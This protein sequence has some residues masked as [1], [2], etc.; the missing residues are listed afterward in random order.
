MTSYKLPES[1][2]NIFQVFHKAKFEIYAVGGAVRDLIMEKQTKDWDFT[3]NARPEEIL[4]IFP[5]GFYNN[6]FGTVGIPQEN[7]EVYE[8][9]TYRT[10]RDYSDRRHPDVVCWGESLEEDL[11]RRDFTVNAIALLRQPADQGKPLF[12]DPF[13]GQKDIQDKVIRAVGD[14]EKRFSEDILRL[15]RAVRI[16]TELGFLIEE[17]TFQAIKNNAPLI[18]KVS[19]ERI[20]EELFKILGSDFPFEGVSLLQSSGLLAQILPEI[21]KGFGIAQKSPGRHHVYDVGEHS[22]LSLKFCPSKNPLVRLATLCHDVGKPV[23]FK[24]DEKG[25]ITFYNHELIGASTARNIAER[26]HFSKKER[27]KFVTLIRWHQFTV[28]E[29]QTDASIRR[30]IKRVGAENLQDIFDL[31]IGDRLGGGCPAATSWRLR[32]FMARTVEVQKHTPST[33]DLKIDGRDVMRE[34]GI[35]PGPKVGQI[36]DILFQEI[37]EDNKKNQEEYLLKRIKSFK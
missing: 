36:L 8:I 22:L 34:L 35:G 20:K 33:K 9:T 21:E 3:T 7:G 14:P 11:A 24:K 26:L 6:V 18:K 5:D 15:L 28:D 27:E 29:F 13:R 2:A 12:I 23:T 19:G 37:T 25:L 31:R 10:E 4:K 30:F 16:A 1:V 17:K 32:K